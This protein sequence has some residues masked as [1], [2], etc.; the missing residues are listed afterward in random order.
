MSTNNKKA[1][2]NHAKAATDSSPVKPSEGIKKAEVNKEKERSVNIDDITLFYPLIEVYKAAREGLPKGEYP[3]VAQ[4]TA[5]VTRMWE[6]SM[7]DAYERANVKTFAAYM[8]LAEQAK[9]GRLVKLDTKPAVTIVHIHSK[10]V[11]LLLTPSSSEAKLSQEPSKTIMP[12]S[13]NG[14]AAL[15]KKNKE[16]K[17]GKE[18]KE[19]G[20]GP[21][22]IEMT[23]P[24]KSNE[25]NP[26]LHAHLPSGEKIH[27]SYFPLCNVLLTQRAEGKGTSSEA[28]LQGILSKHN[29]ISH[30]VSTPEQFASY[31]GRAERD[32][33]VL[34]EGSKPGKRY[35]RLAPRL[36][37][38]EEE[39]NRQRREKYATENNGTKEASPGV[40]TIL[41][42]EKK[43]DRA[44]Q[45]K[46]DELEGEDVGLAISSDFGSE[47]A[48]PQERVKFKPLVDVLVS[49][50]R[51]LPET[52]TEAALSKVSS[53]LVSHCAIDGKIVSP[54]AWIQA[55]GYSSFVE[56][57][58]SAQ[59]KGF[60][61]L[62]KSVDD[63]VVH[64]MRLAEKYEAMF[65]HGS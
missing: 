55:Q 12:E 25:K 51:E 19:N 62:I 53:S 18:V 30:F 42:R 21:S 24:Q 49:L 35:I 59:K 28:F 52:N 48:T 13:S 37:V 22:S 60:I 57:Y 39:H 10:Y 29:K 47:P 7:R 36:C 11:N 26:L 2:I 63:K 27:V 61:H 65:F 58:Q 56:Y 34:C 40:V 38:G 4:M 45:G 6:V 8:E 15:L 31:L 1:E 50:R 43:E 17:E 33:I 23:T 41:Q 14:T 20:K 64:R 46:A 16:A 3:T 32:N 5:Q 44:E 9:I 54:G